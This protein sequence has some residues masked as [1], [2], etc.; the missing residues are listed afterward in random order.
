MAKDSPDARALKDSA[1]EHLK[2][3]KF[4]KAAEVLE[5]LVQAEPKDLQHRLR[6]GDCYRKLEL[7]EKAIAQYDAAA[8]A[9]AGLGQLIKAIAAVKVILEIDPRNTEAQKQLA[10]MNEQRLGKVGLE[11]A[12]LAGV[13]RAAVARIVPERVPAPPRGAQ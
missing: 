5:Q 3:S 13:K 12:G 2:K 10:E 9:Y 6:L 8:R 4:D 7:T 1:A 11:S